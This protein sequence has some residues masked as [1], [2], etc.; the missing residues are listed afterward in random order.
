[1]KKSSLKAKMA[2]I[3]ASVAF[4]L[5]MAGCSSD[6]PASEGSTTIAVPTIELTAPASRAAVAV[7]DFNIDFFRNVAISDNYKGKNVSCSPMSATMLL[8]LL[9]NAASDE[10]ADEI[11]AV[12]GYSDSNDLND[13]YALLAT[14]LPSLDQKVKLSIANSVWYHQ[15]FTLTKDFGDIAK[16]YYKADIFKCDLSGTT[17]GVR[18]EINSWVNDNT[19]GLIKNI[20][21]LLP[22]L[23]TLINA[24]YF[25]AEWKD[26]FKTEDTKKATFKGVDGDSQ[27]DMMHREGCYLYERTEDYEAIEMP[28]GVGAFNVAF[29]MPTTNLEAFI[30]SDALY[31]LWSNN[32]KACNI[33]LSLPKFKIA[34]DTELNL[35]DILRDM[36]VKSLTTPGMMKFFNESPD[37][38]FVNVSQKTSVEFSEQGVES[39]SATWTN[40]EISTGFM[41]VSF[42]RPFIFLITEKSTKSMLF[43]GKIMSL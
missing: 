33:D 26:S 20:D 13:L 7:Q 15:E 22:A 12:L 40:W 24:A 25:K 38:D 27:I 16:G 34:E 41:P 4:I 18:D 36:G 37:A 2:F 43:A 10:T 39:A 42:D 32:P 35:I 21:V 19:N 14:Q 28:F 8:S 9:S 5:P 3:V 23:S 30:K 6:E 11:A 31:G 29:I 17:I 1:M